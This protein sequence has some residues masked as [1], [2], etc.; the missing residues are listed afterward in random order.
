MQG[1]IYGLEIAA[2][3]GVAIAHRHTRS[4]RQLWRHH[5]VYMEPQ[6]DTIPAPET[7]GIAFW[8]GVVALLLSVLVAI[9]IS[10]H[11]ATSRS[12]TQLVG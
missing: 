2:R 6:M 1:D 11:V 7:Y 4:R 3:R 12:S 9:G 8:A 10:I 5:L